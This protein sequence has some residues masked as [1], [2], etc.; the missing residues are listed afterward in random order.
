M[1]ITLKEGQ[2]A[3]TFEGQDQDG[4]IVSLSDY[5]GQKVIL[6]FYPKDDTPAALHRHV[7]LGTITNCLS[8][9]DTRLSA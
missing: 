7:T 3:P 9:M 5:R 1:L 6:Y 4:N 8:I 2:K